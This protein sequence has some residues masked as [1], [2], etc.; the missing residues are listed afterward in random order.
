MLKIHV[1]NFILRKK[2]I[3]KIYGYA[4]AER[5]AKQTVH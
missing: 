2:R 3:I 1:K 5:R 4:S